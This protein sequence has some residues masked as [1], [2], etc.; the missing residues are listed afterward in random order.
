ML[1]TIQNENLILQ[2]D[3]LGAQ[4]MELQSRYGTQFLWD[5]NPE[6]WAGRAINLFPYVG[7]LTNKSYEFDGKLYPMDI[8]GFAW[9][10]EMVVSGNGEDWI[11]FR[12]S[13]NEETRKQY[14]FEFEYGVRYV[15]DGWNVLITY[16]V[17]N[18]DTRSMPFGLGGHPGFRVPLEDGFQFEDYYLEF[19]DPC[20]PN[21]VC[22]TSDCYVSGKER[23]YLL[24]NRKI[25]RLS[26]NMFDGDAIVLKNM[27]REVTLKA[28]GSEKSITVTYP[29]MQYLG[30]WHMPGTDAPYIC[31]EP[32][33][34]Q[35][36]RKNIVEN[37]MCQSDLIHL[38][39]G[40]EYKNYWKIQICDKEEKK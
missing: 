40:Q 14:P 7:R 18:N 30:L 37:L 17:K 36:S 11:E 21:Q 22:Y 35:A 12:L 24:E 32:W 8:H 20:D 23:R 38:E 4:M 3:S 10:S 34:S 16:L 15:L 33:I 26:H 5:G 28:K 13:S 6:Y 31:I 27:A 2:I 39:Q 29:Q 19:S 25:L 1:Y 9:I